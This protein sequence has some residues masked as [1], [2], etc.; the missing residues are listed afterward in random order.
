MNTSKRQRKTIFQIVKQRV[1]TLT[2]VHISVIGVFLNS[3]KEKDAGL[4]NG[5]RGRISNQKT[6]HHQEMSKANMLS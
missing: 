4:I 1:L 2:K 5:N 6:P 3:L